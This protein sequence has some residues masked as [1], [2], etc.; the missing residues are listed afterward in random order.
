M[1]KQE[2]VNGIAECMRLQES[3]NGVVNPDWRKAKNPWP[4]AI[5]T[6]CAELLDHLQWKWWKNVDAKVD[7][8][9]ALLEVVD[10]FHFFLSERMVD[11]R[12]ALD[13]ANSH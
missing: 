10:I 1:E 8:K 12:T 9:Q 13:L 5:W 6:E 2:L 11:R 3:F 4:R 7:Q